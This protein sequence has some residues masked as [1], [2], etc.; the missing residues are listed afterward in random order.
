VLDQGCNVV[1]HRF[2]RHR[3]VDIGCA[4]MCLEIYGDDPP[5]FRQQR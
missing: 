4:S 1:R 2:E 3:A 5:A